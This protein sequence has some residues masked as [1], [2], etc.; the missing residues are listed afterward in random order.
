M[1]ILSA[2]ILNCLCATQRGNISLTGFG[3]FQP[4]YLPR[5]AKQ[6]GWVANNQDIGIRAFMKRAFREG[7]CQT[8]DG[9]VYQGAGPR[10]KV[11]LLRA[12]PL[13]E[14]RG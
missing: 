13:E 2:A 4:P 12:Q 14:R 3:G 8:M 11:R 6:A 10:K 5:L 7:R 1:K 9:K